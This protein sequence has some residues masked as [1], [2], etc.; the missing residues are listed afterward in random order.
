M[1][2][3][4]WIRLVEDLAIRH[5]HTIKVER[6]FTCVDVIM[7]LDSC[8]SIFFI[9]CADGVF[10]PGIIVSD[11][12]ASVFPGGAKL[13]SYHCTVVAKNYLI[14]GAV[15]RLEYGILGSLVVDW[16]LQQGLLKRQGRLPGRE[17]Q[18]VQD[19]EDAGPKCRYWSH[20]GRF[21]SK[22]IWE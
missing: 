5:L 17:A 21:L 1:N 14:L 8:G 9:V 18:H 13:E 7:P 11:P 19:I 4:S 2:L 10:F 16:G 3:G 6:H 20:L 12:A 15:W 22:T